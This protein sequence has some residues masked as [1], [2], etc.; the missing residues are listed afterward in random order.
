LAPAANRS[1]AAATTPQVAARSSASVGNVGVFSPQADSR[2]RPIMG[3]RSVGAIV[4]TAVSLRIR[5]EYVPIGFRFPAH[6]HEGDLQDEAGML[7][8]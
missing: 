8:Y 5:N 2:E 6:A 7:M 3:V 4:F 1:P